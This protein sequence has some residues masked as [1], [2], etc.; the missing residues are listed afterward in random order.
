MHATI[1]TEMYTA[2][3]MSTLDTGDPKR[4]TQPNDYISNLGLRWWVRI[5]DIWLG[6]MLWCTWSTPGGHDALMSV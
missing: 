1:H 4:S 2:R 5:H 3:N 6:R